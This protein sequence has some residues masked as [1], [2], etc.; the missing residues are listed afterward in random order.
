MKDE[1]VLTGTGVS[2]L[3]VAYAISKP[4]VFLAGRYDA[5]SG[6]QIT[7]GYYAQWFSDGYGFIN[8]RNV[9]QNG[10][11]N[12]DVMAYDK[13]LGFTITDEPAQADVIVG[14]VALNQ[15]ESGAAAVAAVKAGSPTSPPAPAPEVHPGKPD[16]RSEYATLGME[17]LHTVTYPTDSLTTASHV[18]R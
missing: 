5:F 3:P 9:H 11:S 13:Q 1:F 18:G 12:Y 17:A 10:T 8:Y 4:T 16:H 6:Y 15:G 7:E 2:E 14:N